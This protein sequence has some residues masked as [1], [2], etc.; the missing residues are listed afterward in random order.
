MEPTKTGSNDSGY[1]TSVLG[2]DDQEFEEYDGHQSQAKEVGQEAA[3]DQKDATTWWTRLLAWFSRRGLAH[4]FFATRLYE[5]RIAELQAENTRLR[6]VIEIDQDDRVRLAAS[7]AREREQ[8]HAQFNRERESMLTRLLG[9]LPTETTNAD[10]DISLENGNPLDPIS[11]RLNEAIQKDQDEFL[12]HLEEQDRRA[13]EFER[14]AA[15]IKASQAE[16]I[17]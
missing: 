3:A 9:P 10:L 2:S 11:K 4:L 14:Q 7:Y 15:E 17:E 13:R 12:K 5:Q 1:A 6:R 8:L 16:P